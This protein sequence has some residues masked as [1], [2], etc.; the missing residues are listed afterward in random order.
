MD[1]VKFY[2]VR[3]VVRK[4]QLGC[5]NALLLLVNDINS[6][7]IYQVYDLLFVFNSQSNCTIWLKKAEFLLPILLSI[8]Y[9][10]D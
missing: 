1:I 7:R 2:N 5:T 9:Y 4:W 3:L 10:F 8:C 6:S